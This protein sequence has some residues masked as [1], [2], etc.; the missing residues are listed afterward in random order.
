M[1][2]VE[3][4]FCSADKSLVGILMDEL[5]I[6]KFDESRSIQ[7]HITEMT[8]IATRFSTLGIIVDDTFLVQST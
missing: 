3:E 4:R 2:F 7:N 6:I 8:K 1:K 5:T